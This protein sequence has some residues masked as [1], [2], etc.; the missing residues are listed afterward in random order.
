MRDIRLPVV[1]VVLLLVGIVSCGGERRAGIPPAEEAALGE[2]GTVKDLQPPSRFWRRVEGIS[3]GA[4]GAGPGVE[5]K[6]PEPFRPASILRRQAVFDLQLQQPRDIAEF[7]FD[8]EPT[9]ILG[10][11]L[12]VHLV[13]KQ[14]TD[15]CITLPVDLPAARTSAIEVEVAGLRGRPLDL[16][17]RARSSEGE[18]GGKLTV[19]SAQVVGTA[20]PAEEEM[21]LYRFALRDAEEWRGRVV[22]LG[23]C[24]SEWVDQLWLRRVSAWEEE[25]DA[26]DVKTW[27]G[28]PLRV[29][30]DDDVR[31]AMLV[32][33]SAPVTRRLRLPGRG[34]AQ[35]ELRTSVAV[36]PGSSPLRF[37]LRLGG[38]SLWAEE[39]AVEDGWREV[40]VPLVGGEEEAELELQV[41]MPS[42]TSPFPGAM[43]EKALAVGFW[44]IPTVLQVSDKEPLNL[45][46]ISIDTLRSD[47]LSLYGYPRATSPH[48]DRWASERAVVFDRAVAASPWTLPSHTTMF[49]GLDA[50][51]HGVNLV[52]ERVPPGLPLLAEQ[53]QQAGYHTRAITGGGY[54]HPRFGLDRGFDAYR[55]WGDRRSAS[56]G[57]ELKVHSPLLRSWLQANADRPFFL[58]FHT[59]AVHGPLSA[60]EPFYEQFGGR[61]FA[62]GQKVRVETSVPEAQDGYR[63][64]MTASI[65]GP[66]GVELLGPDKLSPFY[67]S[68]IAYTDQVLGELFTALDALD[69]SRRTAVL[70]TSD[71]GE[72]LGE[73]GLY[74][75]HYLYDENLQVPFVLALPDEQFLPANVRR[76]LGEGGAGRRVMAQVRTADVAPTL[77]ELAGLE[78]DGREGEEIVDGRSVL[79]LLRGDVEVFPPAWSY[80]ANS[81][82]GLS[83]Q[84]GRN[85]VIQHVSVWSGGSSAGMEDVRHVDAGAVRQLQRRLQRGFL[86]DAS[87]F[88]LRLQHPGDPAKQEITGRFQLTPTPPINA[89][90][91][92]DLEPAC[93]EEGCLQGAED[94]VQRFRL[95][96][97][98]SF[99]VLIE[100]ALIEATIWASW[101]G[102]DQEHKLQIDLGELESYAAFRFDARG[103]HRLDRVLAADE[104]GVLLWWDGFPGSRSSWDGPDARLPAE[105]ERQLR[106][107]GYLR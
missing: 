29:D 12:G 102:E 71:H 72:L 31:N 78:L 87:G 27:Q 80:A 19:H 44:Q 81:N 84:D 74:D 86:R 107:L 38:R 70:L 30:L 33:S 85:K 97:G 49:T 104:V 16:Y 15:L 94:E 98:S 68:A 25:V 90:K 20:A 17:W 22:A 8:P 35:G 96:V 53:L 105:L 32:T 76:G 4:T 1:S 42:G 103:W 56:A 75:H 57:H 10:S 59:Y 43:R 62:P 95:P 47:H 89:L 14:L 100:T 39:V 45:I 37:R 60:H 99:T 11:D 73:Y 24:N 93:L 3:G 58:F 6:S 91:S 18:V 51:R 21:E 79:S 64:R 46:L 41:E 101:A 7:T 48:L 52:T 77:L 34:E 88:R 13:W 83:L 61:P 69:L 5:S 66:D 36:M 63:Q 82:F 65:Q 2:A 106:A 9:Q 54:L 55:Y 92:A 28:R 26:A 23:L 67:D 40:R 50:H